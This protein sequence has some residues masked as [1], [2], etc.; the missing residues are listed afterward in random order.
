LEKNSMVWNGISPSELK[1]YIVAPA[2]ARLGLPGGP[3]ALALVT[4]TAGVESGAAALVQNGGGPALGL[5]QMEPATERDCWANFLS[6]EPGLESTIARMLPPGLGQADR[7][8]QLI[9][10]LYYAAAMCRVKYR[11]APQALPDPNDPIGMAEYWKK[12][13]NSSLGAG[14]V[15]ASHVAVFLQAIRA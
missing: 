10:N 8:Q 6:G 1:K 9:G 3:A 12:W 15:D 13:Y 14:T 5:W 11:R 2:L 7:C 4:G